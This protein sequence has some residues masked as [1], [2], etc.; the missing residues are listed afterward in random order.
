MENIFPGGAEDK[1]GRPKFSPWVRKIPWKRKW[2]LT[3][4]FLPGGLPWTEEPGR[5]QSMGSRRVGRN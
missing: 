4:I 3:P 2:Q 5:L 1:R